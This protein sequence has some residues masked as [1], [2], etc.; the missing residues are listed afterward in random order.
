MIRAAILVL[1]LWAPAA[2]AAGPALLLDAEIPWTE[3]EASFGG[4]SGLAVTDDGRS[5]VTVSDKGTWATGRME[6]EHGRLT[7][8]TMTGHGPLHEISGTPLDGL[9][10]DA[11][12]LDLDPQGRAYVSFEAFHR[13]RR[14]DR[15]DGPAASVPPHPDFARL[16]NNSGL[17]ALTIDAEGTLYV[18]PERSGA[19]DRPFPVY[20]FRNGR[21]DKDLRLRRD[22][23][24]LVVDADFGPDGRLYV[25]E[26][27]FRWL[28]GFATR[29]RRFTLGPAGLGDEITLFETRIGEMDNMEGMSVWRDEAGQTRV[30]LLSDDNFFALQRTIIAEFVLAER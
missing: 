8:I 25:L 13:V 30:T 5:F 14:Y 28:G 12:G 23:E 4:F 18:I 6:R 29:I 10:V 20:R 19:L 1:L 21:W 17:E 2:S 16:Q 24:F 9:N 11:E 22:G 3:P 7:G 26:R 15:L 27:S